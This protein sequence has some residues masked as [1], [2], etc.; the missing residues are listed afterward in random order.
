MTRNPENGRDSRRDLL[1]L[2]QKRYKQHSSSADP[3]SI[4]AHSSFNGTAR[5][6]SSGEIAN[7][8][9]ADKSRSNGTPSPKQI[10]DSIARLNGS[11]GS[12]ESEPIISLNDAIAQ[13]ST[14]TGYQNKEVIIFAIAKNGKV[15]AKKLG[16]FIKSLNNLKKSLAKDCPPS[17][18]VQIIEIH[19]TPDHIS[20]VKGRIKHQAV[21]RQVR[22][23]PEF[24]SRLTQ[25]ADQDTPEPDPTD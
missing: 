16:Q 6:A 4:H 2:L 11:N 21:L 13:V 9:R 12:R 8:L 24:Y 20:Q 22:Q 25:A 19:L 18:V 10:I 14:Q 5:P 7:Q 23:K 17:Q 15:C 3:R 1:K